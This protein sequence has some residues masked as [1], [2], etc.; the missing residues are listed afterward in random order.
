MRR[1]SETDIYDTPEDTQRYRLDTVFPNTRWY[2]YLRYASI[3]LRSSAYAVRGVF[4]DE[5]W[6]EASY[7][8]LKIIERCGGRFHIRGLDN[9][10][11]PDGP[12]VIIS[13][14]MGTIETQVFPCLIVPFR[15]VTFIVKKSLVVN[16]IFGPIM[17]SRDPVV[18]G[19]KKPREDMETVLRDGTKT[20]ENGTSIVVFPQ[21]TR[22]AG[23]DPKDFNSLG[24]KLARKAG[25]TVIPA[26]IKTD[27]WGNGKLIKEFGPID[28]NK[29]I[30]MVFGE[31]MTIQGNGR[32]EHAEIVD[33][34]QS[35]MEV[36]ESEE[37]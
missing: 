7:D 5:R 15:P 22:R 10:A 8:I 35:H 20:L 12:I 9:L 2:L 36:W 30:H 11:K 33:L 17:R 32:K 14:H 19:R 13:N 3:V 25:V 16:P 31:P 28:R 21:A 4:D 34:I 26:A 29:P 23:F 24:V 27:F 6:F 37:L 18:V 1:I